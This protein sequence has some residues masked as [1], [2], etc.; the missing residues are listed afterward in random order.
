MDA[1]PT[2]WPT[3]VW[4]T[5]PGTE[6]HRFKRQSSTRCPTSVT[7]AVNDFRKPPS[8]AA[9]AA[10]GDSR[11]E[12]RPRSPSINEEKVSPKECSPK[13]WLYF[14]FRFF[15]KILY[16]S[17]R[18]LK[19][20]SEEKMTLNLQFREH[21]FFSRLSTCFENIFRKRRATDKSS[22]L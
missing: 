17:E 21:L 12:K 22:T 4:K 13:R 14:D 18:A 2:T 20:F 9:S 6:C 3:A 5:R 16:E 19:I 7:N 15:E 10:S 11:C 1:A 8:S